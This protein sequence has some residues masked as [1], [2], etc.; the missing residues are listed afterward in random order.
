VQIG[1]FR[2]AETARRIAQRLREQKYRVHESTVSVRPTGASERVTAGAGATATRDRDRY[3]VVVTSASPSEVSAT[4]TAK[5]LTSRATTEG[6]V[7]TPGLPLGEAVALSQDLTRDGLAVRV[8][9]V[10]AAAARARAERGE[11]CAPSRARRF[12]DR[13]SRRR[14]RTGRSGIRSGAHGAAVKE[15][16]P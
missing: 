9:R 4:L 7:I 2:D 12:T 16:S 13:G 3:E 15:A 10:E 6:A 5:G 14:S 1:A 11:A 8:Q